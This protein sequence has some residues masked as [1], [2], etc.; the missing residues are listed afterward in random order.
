MKALALA[1]ITAIACG[2]HAVDHP[3]QV[4][5]SFDDVSAWR[6]SGS[7]G[8]TAA[9]ETVPGRDGRA[10]RL[11]FDLG[12]T[13]GYAVARRDLPL[14]LPDDFELSFDLRGEVPVNNLEIKLVDASGDNVW[15]FH[16]RNYGFPAS[17]R[18]VVI[19]RRQIEFAW[20]PIADHTLRG[21]AAIE[22]VVSAGTGGGT[23]HIDVDQL[24][25][26]ERP[27]PVGPPP[28]MV[29][30]A[31]STA[32]GSSPARALDGDLT[33][34]WESGPA[35]TGATFMLDL[36]RERDL[37]G[38]VVR[39]ASDRFAT[40]FD[41]E[42]SS[43]GASWR[44]AA[45]IADGNGGL[46]PIRTDDA[47]ARFVR[48]R[49]THGRPAGVAI[50]ELVVLDPEAGETANAFVTAVA[51]LSPRGSFPR[52]FSGEQ[53]YWT[54]VGV[55]GGG[56]AASLMSEDGA[57]ELRG[58]ASLE[59]FIEEAG[60][61]TSWATAPRI[62]PSLD[63]GYL[64]IPTVTWHAPAWR[65]EVTALAIGDPRAAQ[66]AVRY[67]VHNTTSEP[68]SLRL[69]L[70]ARPFQVNPPTQWLNI[71]GGVRAIDRMA[72][73]DESLIVDDAVVARSLVSPDHVALWRFH[74]GGYPVTPIAATPR[75]IADPAGLASG[76]VAYDLSL[77]PHGD[78]TVVIVAPLI[79]ELPASL[80]ATRGDAAQTWFA[81]VLAEARTTW[82][83]KLDRVAFRVPP[84]GASIVATLRS[85]L[86]YM[87]MSRDGPILRPGTR[88][89]ARAWIRDG[90]M[91][92]EA[93]LRLGHADVAAAFL[94]WYAPYQFA[95]GK[96]PCC[97]EAHGA[98]PV[99]END[100]DGELIYLAAEIYRYTLDTAQLR[101]AWPAVQGAARHLE[102]LRQSNRT[103]PRRPFYG[104]LPPSIS[105]EGYSA[106]PAYSYWDD[107]W[108][109]TGY[110]SAAVIAAAL[111]DDARA[112][113]YAKQGDEMRRDV[114]ASIVA[115]SAAHHVDYIPGAADLG[116]FDATST[117]IALVPAGL[118]R[119][120]PAALV[121]ATFERAWTTLAGRRA[122]TTWTDYTPYELRLVGTFVRLGWRAR[123][124]DAL[125]A[126]LADRRPI[127]WNQWAEVV[128][129][130]AREPRFIGDMP[131]AWVHSDFARSAL[132]MFAYERTDD[133]A[134]VLAAGIP[135]AWFRKD[136]FAVD[137][138]AI[139]GGS[140]SYSASGS[141]RTITLSI[142]PGALPP[143][144]FVFPWPLA[145]AP[146][147]ASIN[148]K[149]A[150]W[151][152]SAPELAISERPASVVIERN[153]GVN[154]P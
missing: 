7:D 59:P 141:D 34:A 108:G 105:H 27:V 56:G 55:D 97:V 25:L 12:G 104:L 66:L 117:T 129:R 92:G 123:V 19:K 146:G 40:A 51:R 83:A 4:L 30:S 135:P 45:T 103:D 138:L 154:K 116:D 28:A 125:A 150:R 32:P 96:V 47:T 140:L 2:G 58:G 72:W 1:A 61:I 62:E 131:H 68:R 136:G 6:A 119:A 142:G 49:I 37:G 149:P 31:S 24:T 13:S 21:I 20:G 89:Y 39:W 86:A 76:A 133:H 134:F 91:I 80:V 71:A 132:D 64:P 145:T 147:R 120:L 118:Q 38:L 93:L 52:G 3:T 11:A 122:S 151:R 73:R 112:A 63:D 5:D 109:V 81:T 152:G 107:F 137:R 46:D 29:A 153:E 42:L 65:L 33:T 8:V 90:A 101:E 82:H 84:E 17:W 127:A 50:A 60:G 23:G 110:A 87:L 74:A 26:R 144:G 10:L 14:V 124:H 126:Y 22:I 128:G 121:D 85:S 98:V 99:P 115:S 113:R 130:R 102:Q 139:P 15:W 79:G 57:V 143:G 16:R 69:V 114:V 111:G 41:I 35:E 106:K 77:A 78:A 44:P 54:V 94:R 95:S 75:A 43:D 9:I 100:S 70:A 53:S 88:S 36:G 48:I 148:G 67:T 18:H